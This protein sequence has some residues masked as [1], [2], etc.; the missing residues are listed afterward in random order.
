VSLQ[1][2]VRARNK[3]EPTFAAEIRAVAAELALG[4]ALAKRREEIGLSLD[5]LAIT[6]GIEEDRL[7]A[8]D[9]GEAMTLREALLL[10]HA[11][12]VSVSVEHDLTVSPK[13]L[14]APQR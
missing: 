13:T 9:E 5:Q 3:R 8:I 4:E 14:V 10:L 11:Q 7:V 2:Y 6:T 12:E 1:E